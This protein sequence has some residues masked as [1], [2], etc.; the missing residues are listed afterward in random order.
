MVLTGCRISSVS[1]DA[2]KGV[3]ISKGNQ[4]VFRVSGPDEF[5]TLKYSWTLK[6]LCNY[7]E[8]VK[9]TGKE[10]VLSDIS[11]DNDYYSNFWCNKVEVICTLQQE[12]VIIKCD[13]FCGPG[14]SNCPIICLPTVK[15]VTLDEKVWSVRLIQ[16]PPT[17]KGDYIIENEMDQISLEGFTT[18][19]GSLLISGYSINNLNWLYELKNIENSLGINYTNITNLEGL[20]NL[21]TIGDTLSIYQNPE[22]CDNLIE[23][24]SSRTK[25]QFK[26]IDSNKTCSLN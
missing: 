13:G 4:V 10:F 2:S 8:S 5:K 12:T 26:Y 14:S 23:D 16:E 25:P 7:S 22:L 6:S 1:P 17:W 15:W 21:E 9:G 20:D 18:I 3:E 11:F 24:F 19:M